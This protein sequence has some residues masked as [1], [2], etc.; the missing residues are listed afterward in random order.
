VV[1]S[2]I[3]YFHPKNWGND[4]QFDEHIFQMGW[5]NHQL[6]KLDEFFSHFWIPKGHSISS[7][8]GRNLGAMVTMYPG[9]QPLKKK[10]GS[11]WMMIN[12]SLKNGGWTS[13]NMSRNATVLCD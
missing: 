6:D 1:V 8:P 3:V 2:N 5:F 12:L 9:S 4:S 7:H 11:F 13:S 10:G